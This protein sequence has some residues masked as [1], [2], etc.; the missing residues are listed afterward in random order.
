MEFDDH[1][2]FSN[3]Y[4]GEEEENNEDLGESEESNKGF[5]EEEEH[6]EDLGESEVS[7][8]D[9]REE[10]EYIEGLDY[11][12][13]DYEDVPNDNVNL[14]NDNDE[15]P[16]EPNVFGNLPFSIDFVAGNNSH[17]DLLNST[18]SLRG[19]PLQEPSTEQINIDSHSNSRN[20]NIELVTVSCLL[21]VNHVH[22]NLNEEEGPAIINWRKERLQNF[23]I[24]KL[25]NIQKIRENIV[26]ESFKNVIHKFVM[27]GDSLCLNTLTS[28]AETEKFNQLPKALIEVFREQKRREKLRHDAAQQAQWNSS[29]AG[30]SQNVTATNGVIN[31]GIIQS[32][33]VVNPYELP[34]IIQNVEGG[35]VLTPL[36]TPSSSVASQNLST[37]NDIRRGSSI[38]IMPADAVE[39]KREA[40]QEQTPN[41]LDYSNYG[42][43]VI[44]V[45]KRKKR[46]FAKEGNV[47]ILDIPAALGK[48]AFLQCSICAHKIPTQKKRRGGKHTTALDDMHTHIRSQ[49]KNGK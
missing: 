10:D 26:A 42:S 45:Q 2:Y 23:N 34:I 9:F 33:P 27:C 37:S 30:A 20:D 22:L 18:N 46:L 48:K 49:H 24:D 14:S 4:S 25:F 1:N 39:I 47:E 16:S 41:D 3:P 12:G 40:H 21:C 36:T 5:G 28:P 8:E 13:E 29:V 19:D 35:V 7:S 44:Q 15:P 31:H 38:N 11:A 43:E 6:D 17:N 32:S